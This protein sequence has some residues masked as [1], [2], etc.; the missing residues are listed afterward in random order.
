MLSDYKG[1]EEQV[2]C[3][4]LMDTFKMKKDKGK[5]KTQNTHQNTIKLNGKYKKGYKVR[6][7]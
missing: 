5:Y 1:E 4:L 2:G 6:G 7:H 3:C